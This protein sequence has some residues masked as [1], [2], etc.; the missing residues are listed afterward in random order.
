MLY[1]QNVCPNSEDFT[2]WGIVAGVITANAVAN[3]FNG[4]VTAEKWS[5]AVDGAPVAHYVAQVLTPPE[6]MV[7]KVATFSVYVKAIL[8]GSGDQMLLA[9]NSANLY[10][11]FDIPTGALTG[12]AVNTGFTLIRAGSTP[13]GGGWFRVWVTY[14]VTDGGLYIYSATTGGSGSYQ[15]TGQDRF[16]IFGA[17]WTATPGP[18]PYIKSD[19]G[20]LLSHG[21]ARPVRGP[22]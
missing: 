2:A 1:E 6:S 19:T 17:Q 18:I 14:V 4:A 5:D 21:D 13:V 20:F 7:G 22:A 9:A 16:Y 10:A 11:V 8:A 12:T 15:G 3:P